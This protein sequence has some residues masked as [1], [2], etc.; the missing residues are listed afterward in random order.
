MFFEW[1]PKVQKMSTNPTNWQNP[2]I[3]YLDLNKEKTETSGCHGCTVDDEIT[4]L[5][6]PFITFIGLLEK[7]GINEKSTF[8]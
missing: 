7:Y 6:T 3:N 5:N 8:G 4:V 1:K 2:L